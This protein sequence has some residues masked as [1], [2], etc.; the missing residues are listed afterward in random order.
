MISEFFLKSR[1]VGK[2]FTTAELW[3]IREF[4]IV[5]KANYACISNTCERNI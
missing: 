1:N 5:T 3:L 2:G 4:F